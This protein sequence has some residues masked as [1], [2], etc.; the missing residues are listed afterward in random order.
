MDTNTK[1]IIGSGIALFIIAIVLYFVLKPKGPSGSGNVTPVK[2]GGSTGSSGSTGVT[3]S[4]GSTGPGGSTGSTGPG[5]NTPKPVGPSG[6]CL[7]K[8]PDDTKDCIYI[9]DKTYA[10]GVWRCKTECDEY[11][12][13]RE[14]DTPNQMK[15]DK[16]LKTFYCESSVKCNFNGNYYNDLT[17]KCQCHTGYTGTDCSSVFISNCNEYNTDSCKVCNDPYYGPQCEKTCKDHQT[18]NG[19]SC[20]CV[21]GYVNVTGT[22]KLTG[23]CLNN[24]FSTCDLNGKNCKCQCPDGFN[25]EK[26]QYSDKKTCSSN[27]YVSMTGTCTCNKGYAG[28]NCQY[29]INCPDPSEINISGE[30]GYCDCSKTSTCTTSSVCDT[31]NYCKNGTILYK[32]NTYNCDDSKCDCSNSGY[33]GKYCQCKISDKGKFTP[34]QCLGEKAVCQADGTYKI[35]RMSCSDLFK[36]YTDEDTWVS[37]CSNDSGVMGSTCTKDHSH[38]L[39]CNDSNGTSI[40]CV[41]G[42]PTDI[43]SDPCDTCNSQ[44]KMCNC[45]S[46]TGNNYQCVVKKNPSDCGPVSSNF[47]GAGKA[48]PTC[49][50]CDPT[51]QNL[52]SENICDNNP[53]T[54]NCIRGIWP[55]LTTDRNGIEY[56]VTE[57]NVTIPIYPTIDNDACLNSN[58]PTDK[59]E[60]GS[61]NWMGYTRF[62][63]PTGYIMDRN[64]VSDPTTLASHTFKS[65][66]DRN[67]VCYWPDKD[68]VTYL[69]DSGKPLCNNQ[70]KFVQSS[71]TTP[72]TG[73]CTCNKGYAGKNCQYSDT[74][75]CNG[76]GKVDDNGNCTCNP[77]ANGPHCIKFKNG[78]LANVDT[79]VKQPNGTCYWGNPFCYNC[80][81]TMACSKLGLSKQGLD[82]NH[83]WS[84]APELNGDIPKHNDN[85][86]VYCDCNATS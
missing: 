11:E 10:N 26:C 63:N 73:T 56:N 17:N 8:K 28:K 85:C 65:I 55:G 6:F 48:M 59:L 80:N 16:N 32:N 13:S 19:S 45:D 66:H 41:D 15:C 4:T 9:C 47:C 61:K 53:P 33:E 81:A 86:N 83:N 25:G 50:I 49:V 46:T 37:N 75:T 62:N 27:G 69:G 51:K 12:Q 72:L 58:I 64:F 70:G 78:I 42:C 39:S 30:N 14:C 35:E 34:N 54:Q 52:Y 84:C 38:H 23:D 24:S 68:I 36:S 31:K 3:G 43:P 82:P 2:P 71:E 7:D 18:Y 57:N 76:N 1:Y 44:G 60:S 5:G 22:C 29:N 77:D 74:V 20:V 79:G 40:T 67:I 21:T